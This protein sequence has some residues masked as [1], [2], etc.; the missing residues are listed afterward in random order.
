M[1]IGPH[2]LG[3]NLEHDPLSRNF[4]HYLKRLT[5]PHN[6]IHA[7]RM[8]H[9]DQ[10]DLGSCEGNTAAE[11]LGTGKALDNRK[12][13]NKRLG[14]PLLSFPTEH[15]AVDLY[16][17]ATT[18]DND[19]FPAT[20]PPEDTGTSAV[21]IAKA[22][23]S[24]GAIERYDWTFTWQAFLATLQKQ[25]VMLGTNWYDSMMEVDAEGYVHISGSEPNGGHAFL[26][27]ACDFKR[28]RVGCT[29]H[30]SNDDGTPWGVKIGQHQGNFWISF[31]DL[32]RLLIHEQGE[33]LVPVLM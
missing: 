13:F 32:E 2:L 9:L 22:L 20:Y 30:W 4:P 25:P 24:F 14:R 16:S 11:W 6:V 3:R 19:E 18:L 8:P 17:K 31:T 10:G 1:S 26:A 29:N 15:D 5:Q 7:L 23:Q 33:S 27:F 12:A 21:G 28:N